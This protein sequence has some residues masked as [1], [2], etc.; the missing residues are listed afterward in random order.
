MHQKLLKYFT[1]LVVT[2]PIQIHI[3]VALDQMELYLTQPQS[4]T[5]VFSSSICFPPLSLPGLH[6]ML[7]RSLVMWTVSSC[8]CP[9]MHLW[10]LWIN[11]GAV[12]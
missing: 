11:Q 2:Q 9:M 4:L 1:P 12:R 5:S 7:Q 10:M 6:S 3:G 8:F